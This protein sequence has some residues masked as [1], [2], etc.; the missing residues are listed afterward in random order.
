MMDRIFHYIGTD[1]ILRKLLR[2]VLNDLNRQLQTL[3]HQFL[4]Y[5]DRNAITSSVFDTRR[6]P[7]PGRSLRHTVRPVVPAIRLLP[8]SCVLLC[9]LRLL[10]QPRSRRI[11]A[12]PAPTPF[13]A[14]M[15][16]AVVPGECIG[17]AE[18]V[19]IPSVRFVR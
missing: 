4:V 17:S 18:H 12:P 10:Q 7:Y 1:A 13:Q 8:Q 5:L 16:F 14:L 3:L 15:F 9:P 6:W 19:I 2:I 11:S